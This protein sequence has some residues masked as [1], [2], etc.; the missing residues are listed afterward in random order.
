M[1]EICEVTYIM[2]ILSMLFLVVSLSF[3]DGW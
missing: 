1:L 2:F 3:L